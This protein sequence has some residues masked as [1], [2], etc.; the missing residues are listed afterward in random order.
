LSVALH[1]A[2]WCPIDTSTPRFRIFPTFLIG[3]SA[4]PAVA[5]SG[6]SKS[7]LSVSRWY[8]S[9]TTFTLPSRSPM[10][11]PM[12]TDSLSSHLRSGLPSRV[13]L[14]PATTVLLDP[15]TS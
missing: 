8:T 4:V 12:L 14:N 9:R 15:V 2:L 13:S 7:R 10:S 6:G 3:G 11:A 1:A 5:G